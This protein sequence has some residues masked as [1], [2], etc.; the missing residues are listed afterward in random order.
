MRANNVKVLQLDADATSTRLLG[1]T[2]NSLDGSSQ[3]SAVLAGTA[4]SLGRS[5]PQSIILSGQYNT[6]N[7]NQYAAF[8][9][10]GFY[11]QIGAGD[12]YAV[13]T[14]GRNNYIGG[15]DL[16]PVLVGGAENQ[17]DDNVDGGALLGG[18]RNTIQGSLNPYGRQLAPVLV[19][20]SDNWIGLSSDWAIILGGDNNRVGANCASSVIAGGTNNMIADNVTHAFAAGRRSRVNHTGSFVWADSQNLDF[21]SAANDSFNIRAQGGVRL[22][23]DTSQYFGGNTRQMLNL[24]LTAYGIG[25]QNYTFYQRTDL[26]GGFAWYRGGTHDN[27]A[28]SPGAGGIEMMRLTSGGLSVNGTFVSSSDRAQK[29]GFEAV[30]THEILERVAALPITQWHYRADSGTRHIGPM[31]QDFQAAFSVGSDNKHIAM[32]DA[33]GVALAAIQGLNAKVDDQSR[34]AKAADRDKEQRIRQLEAEVA[35]LRSLVRQLAS[36][37][38]RGTLM[39][40]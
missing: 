38:Q 27:A 1:G 36:P 11:N 34:E 28:F 30:N 4:N 32:V 16:I 12:Q 33:D 37:P 22:N 19:G 8:L 21:P 15:N 18:F 35:E 2:G 39:E 24:W 26:N 31:A 17:I 20:G 25:V 3:D 10:G 7:S 40:P 14:G 5:A 13:L 6:I 9:G 23:G 29:E